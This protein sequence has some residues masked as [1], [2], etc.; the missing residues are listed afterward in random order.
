MWPDMFGGPHLDLTGQEWAIVVREVSDALINQGKILLSDRK[1][2]ANKHTFS[3][4]E[5]TAAAGR[6][7]STTENV[8]TR[9]PPPER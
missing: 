8:V 3:H 4:S 9:Q 6:N 1:I 7:I 2:G 5:R